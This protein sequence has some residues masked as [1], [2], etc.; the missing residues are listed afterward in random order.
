[1]KRQT[2]AIVLLASGTAL[3]QSNVDV[4]AGGAHPLADKYCWGEN[5][6][7]IN[8]GDANGRAQG[9][10]MTA[11]FLSGYIWSENA[12]WINLGN[13]LFWTGSNSPYQYPDTGQQ[14]GGSYG[15]N[16]DPATG[17][18]SGHAWGENIGW[19]YFGPWSSAPAGQVARISRFGT[20]LSGRLNGYA[21][22]ENTGWINLDTAAEGQYV[23][24][25]YPNCDGS[26]APPILN[27]NDFQ[28]FLN[29]FAA[30]DLYA[31]CDGSTVDP[32]LNVNDFQCFINQFAAGCS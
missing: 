1:M 15:V 22:S 11:R 8:W 31:N 12:G 24:F 7:W 27:I 32:V 4:A 26:T 30:G 21:W 19:L 28:C 18:L 10:R 3:A 25:C 6:G 17:A 14:S 20:V 5:L 29:A 23:G 16:I 2:A 9:A 13:P